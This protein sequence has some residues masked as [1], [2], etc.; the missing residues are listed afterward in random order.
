MFPE[1]AKD[2]LELKHAKQRLKSYIQ[3]MWDILDKGLF[4][5]LGQS[6][7]AR[8]EAIIAVKG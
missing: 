3:A 8:C 6:I 5:K 4:D 1:V 2:K 7:H